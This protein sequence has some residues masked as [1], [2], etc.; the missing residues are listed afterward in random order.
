MRSRM[1]W[2]R[3][4]SRSPT[5][6]SLSSGSRLRC[7]PVWARCLQAHGGPFLFGAFSPVDA[8]F[9]PVA[10]RFDSYGVELAE[11]AQRFVNTVGSSPAVLEFRAAAEAEED[12]LPSYD[13]V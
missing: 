13:D 7:A 5:T 11:D 4:R 2:L 9:A 6:R 12:R 10:L 3:A 1:R 8:M